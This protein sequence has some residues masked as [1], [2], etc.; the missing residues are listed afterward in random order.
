VPGGAAGGDIAVSGVP[1][2]YDVNHDG[3]PDLGTCSAPGGVAGGVCSGATDVPFDNR[4]VAYGAHR[5]DPTV[6]DPYVTYANY[7]DTNNGVPASGITTGCQVPFAF[8]VGCT[9]ALTGYKPV[10]VPAINHLKQWGLAATI[11]WQILDNLQLQSI[12]SY[13][14]YTNTFANDDDGS[15]IAVQELLQTLV[16]RQVSQEVRLNGSFFNNWIE[17]TVGGFYHD[18]PIASLSARVDL[19]YT[20]FDFRHGPDTT[21]TKT[22][23]LYANVT[24]HP[25]NKLTVS[26]GVR[27][28]HDEKVYTFHRHNPDGTAVTLPCTGAP[29]WAGQSANCA[30]FGVEGRSS[31]F[32]GDRW[33]YRFVA[34]YQL[35]SDF[36]A[37]AQIATGYK[38]GGVNARPF[39]PDQ[40]LPVNPETLT[41]YEAGWKSTWWNKVRFNGAYFFN[42]YKGIQLIR[43]DCSAFSLSS[44]CLLP[45]NGGDAHV[46]GLE[47]ELEAHPTDA[48]EIDASYSY[49]HFKYTRISDPSTG[50]AIGMVTPYTPMNQWSIG[51][52]WRL[53]LPSGWGSVTPRI[54]VN[55]Q[56]HQYGY[57][58]NAMTNL[59]DGY[60]LENMHVTW[61][62]DN[63]VWEAAFE[64]TNLAD[65]YYV[66][67]VNDLSTTAGFVTVQPGMPREWNFSIKRKF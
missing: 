26:A 58:V 15:P 23:A 24:A 13:R 51:A 22:E 36:M 52:Q 19:P 41:A 1:M 11:D 4:F 16:H 38:G 30:V 59:I 49:I 44:T 45:I 53:D 33:D 32:S 10:V 6:N 25:T 8:V 54:D 57:A 39:V 3:V 64:V 67:S 35:T 2:F 63:D 9:N 7:I 20:A 34:N 37:Y 14:Y 66:M 5:G 47:G 65:K 62:S 21:P 42:V 50:V 29:W 46:W 12:T 40:L 18:Q 43:T 48:I 56:T 27:F 31:R 17:Y 28:S 60:D 55:Y 61:R